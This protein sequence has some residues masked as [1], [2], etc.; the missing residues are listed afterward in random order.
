MGWD[1]ILWG[2]MRQGGILWGAM[3]QHPVGCTSVE[4]GETPQN[5]TPWGSGSSCKQHPWV[6]EQAESVGD[7]Q[8]GHEVLGCA[9]PRPPSPHPV[10]GTA[11]PQFPPRR[12]HR[13]GAS[14]STG[15]WRR[16]LPHPPRDSGSPV[17]PS[18]PPQHPQ[19]AGAAVGSHTA[20]LEPTAPSATPR[21]AVAAPRGVPI[22]A[23][24]RPG[25]P[26]P[27]PQAQV[28][29]ELLH[30]H[31]VQQDEV[32]FAEFG[33]LQLRHAAP[34][35]T[36]FPPGPRR[37]FPALP[38]TRRARRAGAGGRGTPALSLSSSPSAGL[39]TAPFVAPH[40]KG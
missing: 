7:P 31:L 26:R 29:Q 16:A 30:G 18:P 2:A 22:T 12:G 40:P 28:L 38:T 36:H 4:Q 37:A 10:P 24:P 39:G 11:V 8:V 34:A 5:T 20:S 27:I 35:T 33:T 15:V 23:S 9:A 17:P 32:G 25:V 19:G 14:C 21:D 13:P 6:R 1:D 3:G